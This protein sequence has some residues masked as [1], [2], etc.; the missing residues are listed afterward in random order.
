MTESGRTGSVR[1][2]PWLPWF[3][4]VVAA[5]ITTIVYLAIAEFL[6]RSRKLKFDKE[7]LDAIRRRDEET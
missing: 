1:T 4:P 6:K 5:A 2:P 7:M 3:W